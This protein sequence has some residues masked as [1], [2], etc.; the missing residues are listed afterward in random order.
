MCTYRRYSVAIRHTLNKRF[1]F[2][3]W[4]SV[5]NKA[6]YVTCNNK[7]SAFKQGNSKTTV[8]LEF[9]IRI[10]NV[11]NIFVVTYQIKY[12]HVLIILLIKACEHEL[13]IDNNGLKKSITD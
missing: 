2:F 9:T 10:F 7:Y 12:I 8:L 4:T 6:L 11:T 5:N 1:S 13:D 3:L